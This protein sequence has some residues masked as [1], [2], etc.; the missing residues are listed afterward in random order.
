MAVKKIDKLKNKEAQRKEAQDVISDPL[1]Y[2]PGE[3]APENG[4]SATEIAGAGHTGGAIAMMNVLTRRGLNGVDHA[5]EG[6][7]EFEGKIRLRVLTRQACVCDR[8]LKP[9]NNPLG[10]GM[11]PA[12]MD[13]AKENEEPQQGDIVIWKGDLREG[14]AKKTPNEIARFEREHEHEKAP[15][16]EGMRH[17]YKEFVVDADGCITVRAATAVDMLTRRGERLSF[18]KFSHRPAP[19][20]TRP[21]RTI[22]NWW[23]REVPGDFRKNKPAK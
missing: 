3:L 7:V 5:P 16:R 8:E 23:F 19:H 13:G 2:V 9:L 21:E 4:W 15:W 6:S 14:F 11:D 1:S 20:S 18:P 12:Y 17:L 22:S 10:M